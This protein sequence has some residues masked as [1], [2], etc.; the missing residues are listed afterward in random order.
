MKPSR[1]NVI[2]V[3]RSPLDHRRGRLQVGNLTIPCALG[4]SGTSHAKREGDGASPVGRFKLLQAFY[5]ADHG[6]RPRTGLRLRP[7][8]PSDGWSD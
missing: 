5:R 6:P 4:R 8:R 7:I 1:V 2:R 3:F